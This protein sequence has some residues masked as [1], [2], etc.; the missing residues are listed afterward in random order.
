MDVPILL[1]RSSGEMFPSCCAILMGNAIKSSLHT[2]TSFAEYVNL[3]DFVDVWM[4]SEMS[5]CDFVTSTG[6]T[7]WR[8]FRKASA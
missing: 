1:H 5:C 4:S 3:Y 7:A 6:T 2:G 8:K